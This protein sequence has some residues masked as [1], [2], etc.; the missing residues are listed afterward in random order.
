MKTSSFLDAFD[1]SLYERVI[2]LSPHL[3][4]AVLSAT[5]LLAALRGRVSRLVVT[6]AAGNPTTADGKRSRVRRGHSPPAGRRAEDRDA[7]HE[8]DCDYVHLGF[9]DCVFRRSPLTG[10]LIYKKARNKFAIA[11]A[12]DRAHVEELFLV[13][14]RLCHQ[15]GRVLLIAPLGIG[16]HV[17]HL[18]CAQIALRLASMSNLIFYEDVPYVF[19]S[20]I[21]KGDPDGPLAAMGRLGLVP[22]QRLVVP[23]RVDE[24]VRVVQHYASQIPLLF[25]DSTLEQKLA[26]RT[27]DDLPSEFFWRA[28]PLEERS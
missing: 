2:V 6:I 4:D 16:F 17:D 22:T 8:L 7:M 28:K 23:Y 24:K 13:L 9:A 20:G 25:P 11:S 26:G 18:I 3:D 21:G 27:F 10:E 5:G 1:W 15:M 12:D 19:D 14:R